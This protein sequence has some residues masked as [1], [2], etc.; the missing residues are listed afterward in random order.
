MQGGDPFESISAKVNMIFF[1]IKI[2]LH[3][4]KKVLDL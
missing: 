4:D 3:D 1:L 2:G